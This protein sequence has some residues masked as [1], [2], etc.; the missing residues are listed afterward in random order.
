MSW[1][2]LTSAPLAMRQAGPSSWLA[3]SLCSA[4]QN[5]EENLGR[6]RAYDTVTGR[7]GCYHDVREYRNRVNVLFFLKKISLRGNEPQNCRDRVVLTTVVHVD[8]ALSFSL[9]TN[10]NK[11]S[12]SSGHF[13]N[14]SIKWPS[15]HPYPPPHTAFHPPLLGNFL[16]TARCETYAWRVS[17]EMRN[18][19]ST[20]E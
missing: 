10:S 1:L 14:S 8:N 13:A 18:D 6:C 2:I 5:R 9:S 17:S 12:S 20:I 4:I 19:L 7:Y 3:R 11:T 16:I 15:Y